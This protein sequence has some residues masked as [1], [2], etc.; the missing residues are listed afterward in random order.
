MVSSR[1]ATPARW[2]ATGAEVLAWGARGDAG[3]QVLDPIAFTV[4]RRGRVYVADWGGPRVIVFDSRGSFVHQWDA[5]AGDAPG[6]RYPSGLA[7]DARGRVY[8]V[9]RASPRVHVLGPLPGG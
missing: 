2:D 4:D 1:P 8:V 9:D 6:L 5:R 3:G 7:V